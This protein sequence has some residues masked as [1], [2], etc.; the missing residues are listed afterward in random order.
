MAIVVLLVIIFDDEY[1]ICPSLD[2]TFS[3]GLIYTYI[4]E[5]NMQMG[6]PKCVVSR[7]ACSSLSIQIV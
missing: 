5:S 1:N 3:I 7:G 4:W 6:R 2:N